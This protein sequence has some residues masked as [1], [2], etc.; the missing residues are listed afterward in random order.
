MTRKIGYVLAPLAGLMVAAGAQ[1]ASSAGSEGAQTGSAAR[2]GTPAS[3]AAPQTAT[4]PSARN[5]RSWVMGNVI[6]AR[7]D[8]VSI[9]TENGKMIIL[10]LGPRTDIVVNGKKASTSRLD[11]KPGA[12]VFAAFEQTGQQPRAVILEV[13]ETGAGI[14]GAPSRMGSASRRPAGKAPASPG[15]SGQ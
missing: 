8:V 7:K 11:I 1:G 14:H 4:A 9:N 3:P 2:A 13:D 6:E 10:Q 12:D 15:T 5:G